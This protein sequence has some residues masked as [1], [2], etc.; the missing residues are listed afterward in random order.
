VGFALMSNLMQQRF[1]MSKSLFPAMVAVVSLALCSVSV[2]VYAGEAAGR[3]VS[4]ALAKTLKASMDASNAKNYA[5]S[6]AKAH[7][8]LSNPKKTPFDTLVANQLLTFA[9]AQQSNGP[10]ALKALQA[11]IDSGALTAAEEAKVS[12]Q[13]VQVGYQQKMYPQAIESGNRM[14]RAGTADA[15]VYT[16]VAQSFYQQGKYSDTAKFLRDYV[17][18]QERRGQ[19]PKEQT[20]LLLRSAS[21]KGQ[22]KAGASDALEKLVVHYPKPEYWD[23]LL[24]TLR[25]DPKMT[26]RQTLHVYRLMQATQTLRQGGDYSEMADLAVNAGMPGEADRVVEQG[27]AANVFTQ[28][29]DKARA[30]RLL[31]SAKKAAAAD[32]AGLPKLETDAKAAKLGDLDY[33]LGAAFFGHGDYAKAVEAL[34]R[35][36]GKGGL[37]NPVEAQLL[38]G[39]AQLRAGAKA[40]AMKTF[41]GIKTEDALMQ[42]I[43]KLWALYAA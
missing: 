27:I 2:S 25:R 24:Y 4:P 5:E 29:A 10:E 14:I 1:L 42:R 30:Q 16:A 3:Q 8:A 11:Q 13:I 39:T 43:A 26:E 41:R 12:K 22:D 40:D 19:S 15:D 35:G 18:D 31:A 36:L 32:K 6:I 17:G 9:Y 28:D 20:L 23:G 37:K 38:L 34:T 21:D 7:E 33:A